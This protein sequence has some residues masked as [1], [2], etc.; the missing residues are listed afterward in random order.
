[1]LERQQREQ[2][3]EMQSLNENSKKQVEDS[4]GESSSNSLPNY[5]DK[6][7]VSALNGKSAQNKA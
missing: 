3:E 4:L 7:K 1:M 2:L 6:N 5:S